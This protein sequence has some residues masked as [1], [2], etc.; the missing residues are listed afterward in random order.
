[1]AHEVQQ[2]NFVGSLVGCMLCSTIN[3]PARE[4]TDT[5][6]HTDTEKSVTDARATQ[7]FHV[8]SSF[9][10]IASAFPHHFGC[11]HGIRGQGN[12]SIAD[13]LPSKALGAPSAAQWMCALRNRYFIVYT[14]YI[15]ICSDAPERM[16]H[17]FLPYIASFRGD[18]VLYCT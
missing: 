3:A 14:A 16:M 17:C 9:A 13:G 10:S 12:S 2:G 4:R 6:S 8:Y 1:M 7:C 5:T 11:V 18:V 15:T